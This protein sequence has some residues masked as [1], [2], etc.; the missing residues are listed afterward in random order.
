M[1]S[2]ENLKSTVSHGAQKAL[3]ERLRVDRR[4]KEALETG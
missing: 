3:R 4:P 1:S 2:G